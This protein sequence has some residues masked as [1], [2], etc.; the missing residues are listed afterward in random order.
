MKNIWKYTETDPAKVI[1]REVEFDTGKGGEAAVIIHMTDPHLNMFTERDLENPV[2]ASTHEH[3][4]WLANGAS[5]PNLERC[6]QYA[7]EVKADQV[8]ITGDVLDFLAE[9]C[10]GLMK[11]HIW[12]KHPETLISL[13]NHEMARK[14]QG[15]IPDESTIESRREILKGCW[16]HDIT[17]E[18]RIIKDKVIAVVL[19]N[20][21]ESDF[22]HRGFFTSQIELLKR[23]IELAR[24]KGMKLMLFYH[25]PLWSGMPEVGPIPVSF[26]GDKA[27][28]SVDFATQIKLWDNEGTLG[29]YDLI[30]HNADVVAGCFCGHFHNDIYSEIRAFTPDGEETVIP[31]YVLIGTPYNK[32]H[33]LK[34]TVK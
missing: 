16:A 15:M 1:V 20:S 21:S 26:S 34:I 14:V 33:V 32:G 12:D 8:I 28:Q 7:Q 10:I 11:E 3:R 13:G 18:S 30:T 29:V 9:G 17:Y 31:Q 6:F 22:G 27:K 5:V 24:K 4:K 25:D 23:D 2:L 19:D